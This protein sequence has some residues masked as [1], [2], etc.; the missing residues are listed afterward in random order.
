MLYSIKE[1]MKG[2]YMFA[3]LWYAGVVVAAL[4]YNDMTQNECELLSAT[5]IEDI[6]ITYDDPVRVTQL[7]EWPDQNKWNVTCEKVN[8]YKGKK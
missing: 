2:N 5:M 8:L 7:K 1:Q 3:T 6:M 4:G